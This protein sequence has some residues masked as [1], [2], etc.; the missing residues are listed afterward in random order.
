MT[1]VMHEDLYNARSLPR[2]GAA[3]VGLRRR[4]GLTQV[5]LAKKARVSR[6]WLI[7]AEKGRTEGLE[8][9]KLIQVLDALDAS[10]VVR[11][12]ADG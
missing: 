5:Q 4:R 11:D 1:S 6:Q 2:L 8:L 12:D 9:G 7:A 10:L 3:L